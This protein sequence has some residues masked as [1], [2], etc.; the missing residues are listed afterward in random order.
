MVDSYAWDTIVEWMTKDKT[1]ETLGNDSSSKGNYV[2]NDKISL[3]Y[4]LYALHRYGARKNT[5]VK[6]YWSYAAKYHKGPI[7][8]GGINIDATSGAK[9]EFTNNDY[10]TTNYNYTIRKELATGSA[11]ET[12]INNIYDMAGNMWEWTTETGK[13]DG[14]NTVRAVLRGGSFNG[15]GSNNPVSHRNGDVATSGFYVLIGFR[16][17]LYIQ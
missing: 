5:N 11:E 6:D 8:S 7:K 16:V 10:D 1:Y 12:K 3:S 9:Y 2:N 14:G 4:A 13:P 17:V 15:D